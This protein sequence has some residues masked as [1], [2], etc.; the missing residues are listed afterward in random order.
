[1]FPASGIMTDISHRRTEHPIPPYISSSCVFSYPPIDKHKTQEPEKEKTI[2]TVSKIHMT[3]K[4]LVFNMNNG[5]TNGKV[6]VNSD[7]MSHNVNY[8]G[9]PLYGTYD[10][11]H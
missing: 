5:K 2:R 3:A 4:G 8:N 6:H 11:L 9:Y 10:Y 7:S 1:M